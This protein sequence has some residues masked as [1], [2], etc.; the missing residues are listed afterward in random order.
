MIEAVPSLETLEVY[1]A[2]YRSGRTETILPHLMELDTA[3]K[4]SVPNLVLDL[5]GEKRPPQLLYLFSPKSVVSFK[6]TF[7]QSGVVLST[8]LDQASNLRDLSLH[9]MYED[10]R[11]G[12]L[13]LR[14]WPFVRVR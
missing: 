8:F 1:T 4:L 13:L 12:E 5:R 6:V 2:V 14:F 9:L 7:S 3:Y 11:P 10:F